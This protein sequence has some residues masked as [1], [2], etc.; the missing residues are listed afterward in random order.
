MYIDSFQWCFTQHPTISFQQTSFLPSIGSSSGS[1]L[2]RPPPN[3]LPQPWSED[4]DRYM[5]KLTVTIYTVSHHVYFKYYIIVCQVL[6]IDEFMYPLRFWLDKRVSWNNGIEARI[7]H[8][9]TNQIWVASKLYMGVQRILEYSELAG[10]Y[11]FLSMLIHFMYHCLKFH[12]FWLCFNGHLFHSSWVDC[13]QT[14]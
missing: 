9:I 13:S 5:Q 11:S 8:T 1:T 14:Q 2:Q 10:S 7:L 12:V 6:F 4:V 3:D